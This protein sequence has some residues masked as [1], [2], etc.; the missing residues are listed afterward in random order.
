[1]SDPER[2]SLLFLRQGKGGSY[3]VHVP[4]NTD[5]ELRYSNLWSTMSLF[6]APTPRLLEVS[7][8]PIVLLKK[9]SCPKLLNAQLANAKDILAKKKRT[10]TE[11]P[12]FSLEGQIKIPPQSSA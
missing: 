4:F 9:F 5:I 3:F 12:F 6:H 8:V 1:M 2:E 10:L 11:N 7:K